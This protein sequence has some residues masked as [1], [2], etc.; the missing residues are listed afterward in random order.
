[1]VEISPIANVHHFPTPWVHPYIIIQKSCI[2]NTS[3]NIKSVPFG[4]CVEKK[5]WCPTYVPKQTDFIFSLVYIYR[6]NSSH[7]QRTLTLTLKFLDLVICLENAPLIFPQT[8]NL[9]VCV[10]VHWDELLRY[11]LWLYNVVN[12]VVIPW[13]P[14]SKGRLGGFSRPPRLCADRE[15]SSTLEDCGTEEGIARFAICTMNMSTI[16]CNWKYRTY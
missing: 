10:T 11:M 15:R 6:S 2:I 9:D 5:D 16:H 13:L 1:M 4:T 14:R 12:C 8:R 3:E 7:A